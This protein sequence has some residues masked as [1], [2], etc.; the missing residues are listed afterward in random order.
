MHQ[1]LHH[2]VADAPWS[3]E[4]ILDGA[5]D[6]SK[7]VRHRMPMADY[8]KAMGMIDRGEA[9]GKVLFTF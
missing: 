1:S 7:I 5:L 4:A 8:A 9:L 6:L 3:D 2:L